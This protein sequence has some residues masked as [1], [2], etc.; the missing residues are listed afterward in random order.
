MLPPLKLASIAK[1]KTAPDSHAIPPASQPARAPSA[2][3]SSARPLASSADGRAR[4]RRQVP[5][6][7]DAQRAP[8]ARRRLSPSRPPHYPARPDF[9]R[10]GRQA[11]QTCRGVAGATSHAPAVPPS[12]GRPER[13]SAGPGPVLRAARAYIHTQGLSGAA[14]RP[15]RGPRALPDSGCGPEEVGACAR[16]A[17]DGP[18]SCVPRRAGTAG[19]PAAMG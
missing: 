12:D 9:V 7:P 15:R 4:A 2:P 13:G 16:V 3:L 19:R 17:A 18:S 10:P 1:R 6:P 14:R 11:V 8:E 5:L